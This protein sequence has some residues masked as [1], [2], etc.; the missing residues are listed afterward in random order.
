MAPLKTTSTISQ[1]AAI[2]SIAYAKDWESLLSVSQASHSRVGDL[3]LQF[4]Q[5]VE[6]HFRQQHPVGFYARQLF[7]GTDYLRQICRETLGL[8]PSRCISFRLLMETKALLSGGG[9]DI[10][11]G[12]GFD[13]Q[14]HFCHFFKRHTGLPASD[15]KALVQKRGKI[16]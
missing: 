12:L 1:Y 9:G 11:E 10:V 13:S 2:K 4:L 15:F 14:S 7:I 16:P 8:S 5:L 6:A 3:C